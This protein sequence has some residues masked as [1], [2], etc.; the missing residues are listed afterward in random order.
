MV[1]PLN[2]RLTTAREAGARELFAR[3]SINLEAVAAAAPD[4]IL[5][6]DED[7]EEIRSELTAIGPVLPLGSTSSGVAWQQDLRL[8]AEAT[9]TEDRA[10]SLLADYESRI[11]AVRSRHAA[12]LTTPILSLSWAPDTGGEVLSDRLMTI[13]LTDVGVTASAVMQEVVDSGERQSF[14]PEEVLRLSR[15]ADALMVV[16][17]SADARQSLLDHPLWRQVPAVSA[18]RLVWA[19]KYSNEGGPLTAN[20]ALDLADQLLATIPTR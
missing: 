10:E 11:A 18:G 9:G 1:S 12:A 6:R 2:S 14:S 15:G 5:G 16:A 4:L 19:D 13:V 8:V 17:N 3:N 7:V 20:H